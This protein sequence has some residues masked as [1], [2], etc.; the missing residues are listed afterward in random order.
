MLRTNHTP[1]SRHFVRVSADLLK[2]AEENGEFEYHSPLGKGFT[3]DGAKK[4][5]FNPYSKAD[6]GP[7]NQ[8]YEYEEAYVSEAKQVL[9]RR[10]G[11]VNMLHERRSQRLQF[12][13]QQTKAAATTEPAWTTVNEPLT[14]QNTA[15]ACNIM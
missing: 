7:A 3:F 9:K 14:E 8:A 10:S 12:Q 15:G 4:G 2:R 6:Q 11:V 13:E 1:K 5:D